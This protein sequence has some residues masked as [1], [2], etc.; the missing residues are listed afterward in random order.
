MPFS[1]TIYALSSGG[2]PSGV[3]VIRLTG[4][5]TPTAILNLAGGLPAPRQASYR[6]LIDDQ[7]EILDHGLVLFFPGPASFTGEDCAEFQI[8]GGR[9]VVSA[10]LRA[11]SSIEGLRQAEAGEFTKRAFIN[12]K[13]DLTSAE[14]LADLIEAETEAQRRLAIDNLEGGQQKL[15]DSWRSRL[16]H[17]RAMIEA[18][19]DFAD[20]SDVPGSLTDIVN[21][22]LSELNKE[23]TTHLSGFHVAEIIR[24]GFR[25]ALVGAPNAGKS[26]LLNALAKRE[27][28]IVTDIAGTTRDL[29]EISLDL[30]GRKVVII[31]TAGLR[32]TEDIVEKIGVEKAINAAE[33]AD[34]ILELVEVGSIQEKSLLKTDSTP[35][36]MIATK[37][38]LQ[39]K[40]YTNFDHA[41]SIRTG[42][43]LAEL[44]DDISQK[45]E[46]AASAALGTIPTRIRHVELLES[47]RN[48]IRLGLDHEEPELQAE[49]FRLASSSLGKITGAVDVEELL[50]VIFSQFC[51]GK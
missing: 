34:L 16:L 26:S 27:V 15:Y 6:R 17:A 1:D 48:H 47:T 7:G 31:D 13:I 23:I 42:N 50:G 20:E 8:H 21:Q 30:N 41:I 45:A 43:G 22:D 18:E 9:A 5:H 33:N 4:P 44:I 29:I 19:L 35:R 36:L 24:D 40:I 51:I 39:Q 3:A 25:V 12:G 11:L 14:G 10:V 28:A 49:Q 38:D 37:T 32:E 2:L 46:D